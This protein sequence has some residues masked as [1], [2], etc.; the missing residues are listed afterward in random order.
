MLRRLATR[1]WSMLNVPLFGTK[2]IPRNAAVDPARFSEQEFPV[3]CPKCG[4]LLRGLPDGNCPECGKPFERGR[5]LVLQYVHEWSGKLWRQ[6]RPG[7][8]CR[9]LFVL[10]F[11]LYAAWLVGFICFAYP[12]FRKAATPPTLAA[13]DRDYSI[14]RG[15]MILWL[16]GPA[17]HLVACVLMLVTY[18][19]GARKRR[20]AVVDAVWRGQAS[21]SIPRGNKRF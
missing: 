21:A 13:I 19:R 2:V 12:G 17:L 8:W 9:R 7:I 14:A 5:L 10:G 4:Y 15:L 6:S 18:P 1:I 16:A 20:R 3:T 11:V